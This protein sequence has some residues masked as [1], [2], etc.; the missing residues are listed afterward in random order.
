MGKI[1]YVGR[2]LMPAEYMGLREAVGWT[3]VDFTQAALATRMDLFSIVVLTE[4]SEAIGC[5]RVIG[6][7]VLFYYIQDLI[8]APKYQRRGV[9]TKIIELVFSWLST[10]AQA[11]AFI[12][13]MAAPGTAG[14]FTRLGFAVRPED[15][16][17]MQLT[18]MSLLRSG[19][20]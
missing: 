14:F 17:G 9:G 19:R 12:G 18:E 8:V 7:G 2:S 4:E 15:G 11:H 10:R 3:P 13:L 1:S 5:C 6:D 20:A 16:P